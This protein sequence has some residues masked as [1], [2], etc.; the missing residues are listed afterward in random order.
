MMT[1]LAEQLA[2]IYH[3]YLA[4]KPQLENADSTADQATSVFQVCDINVMIHEVNM[5][6]TSL[7]IAPPKF[8]AA[9]GGIYTYNDADNVDYA[10][11]IF[12]ISRFTCLVCFNE[13][14]RNWPDV[15]SV[16]WKKVGGTPDSCPLCQRILFRE[17][18]RSPVH[19]H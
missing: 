2:D 10:S 18:V 19:D 5:E 4:A 6:A 15:E 12:I 8:C 9:G 16:N 7:E 14:P 13:K 17:R 11:G 3:E 1:L